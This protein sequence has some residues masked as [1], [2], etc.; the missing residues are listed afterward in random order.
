MTGG[1]HTIGEP[2]DL[3]ALYCSG[4][5]SPEELADFERHLEKGCDS[6]IKEIEVLG[7]VVNHLCH[8]MLHAGIEEIEP[9]VAARERLSA[10]IAGSKAAAGDSLS[11]SAIERRQSEDA[12]TV[13]RENARPNPQVW[14]QWEPD[15]P[16]ADI[17]INLQ[18]DHR[19]ESTG[20]E[21]IDI[22]RLF[23]DKDRNQMTA[24]VRM[25]AG[26]SY[27]RHIHD[28]AEECLVLEGD[29]RAGDFQFREGDYH[30]MSAGSQHGVQSTDNGCLLLIISSL[31][32][33]LID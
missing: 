31:T 18:K 27:P 3:A 15:N 21:G 22:R 12:D 16:D 23:I 5:M 25:A 29:L 33:E 32:D 1:N 2:V 11:D 6:C 14:K 13:V 30:R 26:T 17:S 4:A 7:A 20:V 19:W 9:P 28:T 10:R 8:G 24:L